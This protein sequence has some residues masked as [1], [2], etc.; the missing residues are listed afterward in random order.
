MCTRFTACFRIKNS[1]TAKL[2][3]ELVELKEANLV[4]QEAGITMHAELQEARK[5]VFDLQQELQISKRQ[6]ALDQQKF[7][8][9]E[10]SIT[11][12]HSSST[13]QV[14]TQI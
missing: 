12:T 4:H 14:T 8:E 9:V 13:S 5:M 3:R 10:N 7:S 1:Q 2:K 11:E 6:T